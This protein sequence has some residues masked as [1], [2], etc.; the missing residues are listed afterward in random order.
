MRAGRGAGV[1]RHEVLH[2]DGALRTLPAAHSLCLRHLLQQAVLLLLV[3]AREHGFKRAA[4]AASAGT[5]C[6]QAPEKLLGQKL[7]GTAELPQVREEHQDAGK[8]AADLPTVLQAL[9]APG[10]DAEEAVVEDL[11]FLS[12]RHPL[13]ALRARGQREHPAR[14]SV[15]SS[16][17]QGLRPPQQERAKQLGQADE[18]LRVAHARGPGNG[19]EPPLVLTE[20]LQ[21]QEGDEAVEVR[22]PVEHRRARDAPSHLRPHARAG[23]GLLRVGI[24]DLVRLVQ[25]HPGPRHPRERALGQGL[26][27]RENHVVVRQGLRG[28]RQS[29]S[30]S[31]VHA[32]LQAGREDLQVLLPGGQ[33]RK[34]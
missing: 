26:V 20:G 34:R 27:R 25:D 18:P 6:P 7:R 31:M 1:L 17:L 5:V 24:P 3:Q 10:R 33:H 2:A 9:H 32:D 19:A 21:P 8:L 29:G 11:L 13:E 16:D 23:L 15:R 12:Q 4:R 22:E 14:R 28:E 30:R